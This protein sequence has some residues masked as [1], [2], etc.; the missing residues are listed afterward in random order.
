[1]KAFIITAAL[2]IAVVVALTFA[3]MFAALPVQA[4]TI[5]GSFSASRFPYVLDDPNSGGIVAITIADGNP[6]TQ[7]S[8]AWSSLVCKDH[9]V[10]FLFPDI[11][12]EP[13]VWVFIGDRTT[14]SELGLL[15]TGAP[16]DGEVTS[17]DAVHIKLN[18]VTPARATSLR[19]M[20][21]RSV[22]SVG[23]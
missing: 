17:P 2:V 18:S 23:P 8:L 11:H 12:V 20:D 13:F 3:A 19:R 5:S 6:L 16:P 10:E 1:M 9:P 7:A 21:F 22:V 14:D 4:F 15:E